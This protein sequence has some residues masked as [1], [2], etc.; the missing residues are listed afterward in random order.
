MVVTTRYSYRSYQGREQVNSVNLDNREWFI[1][2]V[3]TAVKIDQLIELI[4][5]ENK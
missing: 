4:N 5:G 3:E 1:A 2:G